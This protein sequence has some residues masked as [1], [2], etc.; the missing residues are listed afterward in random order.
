V[1]SDSFVTLWGDFLLFF[2][3]EMEP[4]ELPAFMS[5]AAGFMSAIFV[6]AGQ[7]GAWMNWPLLGVVLVAVIGVNVFSFGMHVVRM[8]VSLFT[9]GGGKA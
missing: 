7:L 2:L 5:Q 6:Y 9:G 1:I 8:V 3:G 4:V